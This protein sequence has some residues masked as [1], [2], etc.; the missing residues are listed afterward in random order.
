MRHPMNNRG[1]GQ[2]GGW[3][4]FERASER[5][6]SKMKME[7]DTNEAVFRRKDKN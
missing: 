4:D 5:S 7:R 2:V 3:M 6:V 1:H